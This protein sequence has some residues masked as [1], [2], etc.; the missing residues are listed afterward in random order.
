M[1]TDFNM[2]KNQEPLKIDGKMP[3]SLKSED[4]HSTGLPIHGH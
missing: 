1:L 4:V 3:H 2:E